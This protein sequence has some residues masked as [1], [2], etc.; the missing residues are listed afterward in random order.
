MGPKLWGELARQSREGKSSS[1]VLD[2]VK[3]KL[4]ELI[5]DNL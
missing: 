2:S 3:A 1:V 4:A 5:M